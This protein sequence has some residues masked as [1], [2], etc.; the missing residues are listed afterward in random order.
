MSRST[1]LAY[2]MT[3]L[4]VFATICAALS[5]TTL[6]FIHLLGLNPTLCEA[7]NQAIFDVVERALQHFWKAY[8]SGPADF[9]GVKLKI[10]LFKFSSHT[11]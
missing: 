4:W 3:V 9:K 6:T 2:M 8:S 1:T 7:V 5:K 11:I 10:A